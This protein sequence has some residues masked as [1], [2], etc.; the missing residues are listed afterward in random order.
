MTVSDK[1]SGF[2]EIHLIMG[3]DW[4]DLA[5]KRKIQQLKADV[6]RGSGSAP[7]PSK[8]DVCGII[9]RKTQWHFVLQD[10][11]DVMFSHGGLRTKTMSTNGWGALPRKP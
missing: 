11:H 4:W 10:G 7:T 5:Q 9:K 8:H 1:L 6:S 3:A 2:G